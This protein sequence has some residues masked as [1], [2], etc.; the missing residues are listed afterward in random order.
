MTTANPLETM[1]SH[2][3]D[4]IR[5]SNM[6]LAEVRPLDL[7]QPSHRQPPGFYG[8]Q[9]TADEL[10]DEFPHGKGS[11]L[12]FF[13]AMRPPS[14]QSK[15]P[16]KRGDNNAASTHRHTKP[17]DLIQTLKEQVEK[18]RSE[19]EV[20]KERAQTAACLYENELKALRTEMNL[21]GRLQETTLSKETGSLHSQI[22]ILKKE[23]ALQKTILAE[24]NDKIATSE[25]LLYTTTKKMEKSYGSQPR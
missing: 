20:T 7:P 9:G 18:L 8:P 5:A 22:E 23:N 19:L 25:S 11:S 2:L 1:T 6:S 3:G 14:L 12:F 24:L 16:A 4:R 17:Q 15:Q 10:P 13:D 21:E